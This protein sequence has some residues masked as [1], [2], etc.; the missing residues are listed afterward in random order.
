[1]KLAGYWTLDIGH[2]NIQCLKS[3]IRC[4]K[5]ARYSNC[6]VHF[7][8]G[9]LR[10][11]ILGVVF[12]ITI[13]IRKTPENVSELSILLI[14]SFPKIRTWFI[15]SNCTVHF[16]E[17]TLGIFI[18]G[19]VFEITMKGKHQKIYQNYQNCW[20]SNSSR[21]GHGSYFRGDTPDIFIGCCFLIWTLSER[22]TTWVKLL[23]LS[24]QSFSW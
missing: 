17:G 4:V 9:T 10:I 15:F 1:M 23:F 14:Q 8:E 2:S 21:Y 7:F 13:K 24:I 6:M 11:F 3:D 12:E 5:L 18:L 19:I 22:E 16:F 20:F